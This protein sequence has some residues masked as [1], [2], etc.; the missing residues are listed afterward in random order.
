MHQTIL[1]FRLDVPDGELA[2]LRHRLRQTRFTAG[3]RDDTWD[4]GTSPQY[5]RELVT[6]WL[7]QYD[8]SAREAA[9]NELPQFTADIAGGRVHFV[10]QRGEGLERRP[11]LLLHGW[12]DS[13]FRYHKVIPLLTAP[14]RHGGDPRDA[15]DVVVPSLPGFAF[16]DGTRKNF[17]C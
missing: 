12:Q 3:L 11:L 5:L 2:D 10:H 9:L 14:D 4:F 8:W 16:T 15:F 7:D 13:F 6:Y 17:P 1:P